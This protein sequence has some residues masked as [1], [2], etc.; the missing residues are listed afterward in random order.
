MKLRRHITL[1]RKTVHLCAVFW[2][3]SMPL[4]CLS[5]PVA[6]DPINEDSVHSLLPDLEVI[7]AGRSEFRKSEDR[8]VKINASD[9]TRLSRTFGEIDFINQIRRLSGVTSNGDYSAGLSIDGSDV[10]QAQYLIDGAP[11]IY[12]YRFGGIFSTFNTPFFSNMLFMR[13]SPTYLYPVLGPAFALTTATRF[14]PGAEGMVNVGMTA[15]SLAV[16]GGIGRKFSLGIAGRISYVD[17]IYRP[18]LEGQR[19]YINFAFNDINAHAA[20]KIND[21]DCLM[22]GFFRSSDNV[23]YDDRHYALDTRIRWNNNL[24]NISYTHQGEYTVRGNIYGSLFSN[25]LTLKMPQL[26]LKGPSS[27]KTGGLSGFVSRS[28]LRGIIT[29]WSG[30]L[31]ATFH[32]AVPQWAK[33]DMGDTSVDGVTMNRKSARLYSLL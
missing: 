28:V 27:L 31:R 1:N 25:I 12:P 17:Q 23:G 16:R 4:T 29:E 10:S 14:D 5:A 30:G 9:I 26:R 8:S 18:L 22:A 13:R 21:S 2:F 32:K 7:Q 19:N 6:R 15:S 3:I 20:W 33:L 11:V 24:L